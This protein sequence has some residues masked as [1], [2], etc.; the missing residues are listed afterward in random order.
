M[1]YARKITGL[2]SRGITMAGVVYAAL[3]L[4]TVITTPVIAVEAGE[5]KAPSL[6]D[7]TL[8]SEEYADGDGDSIKET[9]VRHYKNARGDLMFNMTTKGVMW[10]WS[11]QSHAGADSE[12]NFVIRDS[13]CDGVYDQKINL[14]EEYHV[15]DCLK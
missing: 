4:I 9:H 6:K 13:N 8:V 5:F 14:D 3:L 12:R 10:A 7:F 11:K 1:I 2:A 15:P